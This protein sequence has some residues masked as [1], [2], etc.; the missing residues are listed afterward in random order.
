MEKIY[1]M[2]NKPK[3]KK[4]K[5]FYN[6]KQQVDD[7]SSFS[8]SAGKPA[9]VASEYKKLYCD[10]SFVSDFR[11][12]S[13]A[14]LALAHDTK[15]VHDVMTGK[16]A[17]GFGNTK[18]SV[19]KSLPWTTGSLIAA[20]TEAY[21][22]KTITASLTSG[23]HHS[24]YDHGGGFCTFNG[25]VI[26]AQ[27]LRVRYGVRKVGIIDFDQHYGDGTENIKEHLRLSYIEHYTLG[28]TG[29]TPSNADEWLND[30][31]DNLIQ[32]FA[33]VDV[34]IY[35]AGADPWVND[36]LGGRLTKEQMRRRD[37]IVFLVARR[38]GVGVAFNLAGGYADVFQH[39]LD[40]HNNTMGE[41]L[42]S[43]N[44]TDYN[45]AIDDIT[46]SNGD[47]IEIRR[48]ISF[49]YDDHEDY[50]DRRSN[51]DGNYLR[52]WNAFSKREKDPSEMTDEELS[53]YI[54]KLI[55]D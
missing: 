17:N 54:A 50:E 55:G 1:K 42:K 6:P 27:V 20:A 49:N 51:D 15:Y 9:K 19:A 14:Q 3:N 2:M 29:V 16:R 31:E 47:K 18:K 41:A 21:K 25:L 23:F 32:K 33:D 10:V 44:G 24:C 4:V 36:P 7:N 37:E 34:L 28:G 8:P 12:A 40:I 46:A 11:P 52:H 26:A 53:E 13:F 39:V 35:Q 48:S 5:V 45:K 22:S 38:L 43:L 30:L